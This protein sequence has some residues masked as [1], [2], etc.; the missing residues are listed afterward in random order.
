M[1]SVAGVTVLLKIFW[2]MVARSIAIDRPTR[3]WR[4]LAVLQSA[5]YSGKP[6][7]AVVPEG[8]LMKRPLRSD[9]TFGRSAVGMVSST[10]SLLDWRSA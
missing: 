5:W 8:V 3:T 10:S 7:Y 6:M 2:E 4:A 1:N 9:L